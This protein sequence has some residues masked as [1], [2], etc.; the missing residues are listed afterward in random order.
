MSQEMQT[1][2]Q[3]PRTIQLTLMRHAQTKGNLEH[4]YNGVIDE[5]L[6]EQGIE[7]CQQREPDLGVEKVLVSPLLRA[8]QTAQICFPNARQIVVEDLRETD[9]GIF[10][11]K[12]FEDLKDDARYR[13]WVESNCEDPCSQGETNSQ[14][15]ARVADAFAQLVSIAASSGESELVIVAHGGTVMAVMARYAQER[16]S[17]HDWHVPNCGGYRATIAL[18]EDGGFTIADPVPL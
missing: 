4:R 1:N 5:P 10:E 7:A 16:R 15:T 11:G 14:F 9:F 3:Q 13:R 2:M 8:R 17:F 6:C 18:D 12:N